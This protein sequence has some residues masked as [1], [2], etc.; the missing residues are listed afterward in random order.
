MSKSNSQSVR[1]PAAHMT[2]ASRTVAGTVARTRRFL[3]RQLWAWPI[4][5]VVLLTT[6]GWVV[7]GRIEATMEE[8]LTS[9]LKTLRDVEVAML[10]TW[11]TAQEHN[12]ESLAAD[13]D[14]RHTAISLLQQGE[15]ES[16][17][18]TNDEQTKK[19]RELL[20]PAIDSHDYEGF[21]VVDRNKVLASS[22]QEAVG[23]ALP[24]NMSDVVQRV[25]DGSATVTRPYKSLLSHQDDD[26]QIRAGV[27]MMFVFAPI[28]DDQTL[29]VVAALGLQI[30]PEAEFTSILQ[31]GQMGESGETYAFDKNGLILSNSRFDRDLKLDGLIPENEPSILNL[32]VRD[33]GGN[34]TTGFR[35]QVLRSQLPPTEMVKQAAEGNAGVDV[36][37][38]RDYRGV[39][40][41]GAWTWLDK[42]GFGVGTE[43]DYS[44]A[45]KPLTI[46]KWTFWGLLSLL[47]ISSIAIFVFTVL[48]SRLQRQARE[49]AIEAKQL[50][51]YKLEEKLGEGAMGVVYRGRH[52]ML[53]RPTAIKL[54]DADKVTEASIGRFEREVQI[55]S[56]LN[57]PNTVAIYDFGHTPEG[58]FYYAMEF[59]DGINLQTLV[60][61][62][63]PQPAGRAIFILRQICG[64][65]YEAHC[66]GLV[67]RDIK[68][69]N[70]MLNQRGGESDVVK[71]LD[72]GLVKAKE[73]A[74]H[75]NE[76]MAGTPLYMS[77]EAIQLPG[78]VDACSD[79]YAV[80]AVGYFLVTGHPVFEASSLVDLCQMH[81]SEPPVPPS[82]RLGQQVP[83][84]L[85]HAILS[86]LEKARAKRPQTARDLVRMLDACAEAS[87]W[88]LDKADAWWSS[89]QRGTAPKSTG[90]STHT[91]DND[92][93]M[94]FE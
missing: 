60:D 75:G 90:Q 36:M 28:V 26:G 48:M 85:E 53:R 78:S 14:V 43:L 35:P 83:A 76:S 51:Q 24:A 8:S 20:G 2:W 12:A 16:T 86:C 40:V 71:V 64:S 15:G 34:I 84:E 3:S 66:S 33:P 93:T 62:Y 31:L 80:G 27:P 55:T 58:V 68:P 1:L 11:M 10:Q 61:T 69:A 23:L 63:G 44:E 9:E 29:Q 67:H 38:Y 52:A 89:H 70:I 21:V 6:L 19:L 91:D 56:N 46:L 13:I 47:A 82:E 54:L 74:S 92:A 5:A 18:P 57:H 94:L 45:Y 79:L 72:F 17:T 32:L 25:F 42:Y 59:L 41:V 88:S 73:E 65:L 77:P 39:P 22:R 81:T 37:G 30:R 49:A 50:G 7:D 87:E 4:I